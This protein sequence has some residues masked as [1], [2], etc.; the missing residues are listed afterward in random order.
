MR[1]DRNDREITKGLR[2]VGASVERLPPPLPDKLVGY[3]NVTYL[4]EIK[5]PGLRDH[6]PMNLGERV[7]LERQAEWRAKWRGGPAVQVYTLAEA[8]A[9]IG[10][11]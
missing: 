3:A 8:L 7:R 9:V 10:A 4:M 1:I 11:E 5:R 2:A 6:A